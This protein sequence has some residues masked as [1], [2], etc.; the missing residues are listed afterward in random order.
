[1]FEEPSKAQALEPY[2]DVRGI[3][4]PKTLAVGEYTPEDIRTY[5]FNKNTIFEGNEELASNIME[6]GKA[7]GLHVS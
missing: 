1:M 3:D 2:A 5:W 4:G 7:P 6:T